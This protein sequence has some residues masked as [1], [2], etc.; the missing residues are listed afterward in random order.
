MS[1][2]S[3]AKGTRAETKVARYLSNHGFPTER[4]A[5]AGSADKG[6]LRMKLSDG[7]EVTLEVKAGE[8]TNNPS[9]SLMTKWKE[10]TL[11]EGANAY[12][13]AVLVIVKARRRFIDSEVWIPNYTGSYGWSWPNWPDGMVGWTMVHLDDFVSMNLGYSMIPGED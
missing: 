12:T 2:P 5:L 9:R 4:K 13:K 11:I 6:D 8:Q 1:N 7:R 3:K 10:Q